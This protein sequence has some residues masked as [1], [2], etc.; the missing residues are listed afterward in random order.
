MKN[1][2]KTSMKFDFM[3]TFEGGATSGRRHHSSEKDAGEE[4]RKRE[5]E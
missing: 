3:R 4:A 2:K 5:E 1:E